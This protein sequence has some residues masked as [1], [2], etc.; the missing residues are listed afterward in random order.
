LIIFFFEKA[1]AACKKQIGIS[2]LAVKAFKKLASDGF[3]PSHTGYKQLSIIREKESK[4]D[5]V[6]SLCK[7]A[8]NEGWNGDWG[9][10]IERCLKKLSKQSVTSR[11]LEKN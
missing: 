3:I 10:R 8:Q 1:V 5:E 9:K 4:F 6:I 11:W 2:H 7:R